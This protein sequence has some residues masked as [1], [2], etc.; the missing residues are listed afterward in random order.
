MATGL[1]QCSAIQVSVVCP[2]ALHQQAVTSLTSTVSVV[3]LTKC[4]SA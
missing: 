3:V 1:S 4:V 2:E